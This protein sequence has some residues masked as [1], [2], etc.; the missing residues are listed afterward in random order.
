MPQLEDVVRKH[1]LKNAYDFG[2]ADPKKILGK[3]IAESPQAKGDIPGTLKLAAK[4][5]GE[6]NSMRKEK[7]EEQLAAYRFE[8]K[9]EKA[10]RIEL[11]NAKEGEVVT[12]FPPEPSGY[13]HIGH[14]KAAF[15][16]Y[17]AAKEY[18]GK[19]ILRFDDTNPE[20]ESQEYVDAIRSGLKWLGI[21]W[22]GESYTSDNIPALYSYCDR[23]IK[24]KKAYVCKCAK[25]DISKC[26]ETGKE[27]KCRKIPPEKQ[28]EEWERMRLGEYGE[29]EAL[30]RYRGD[31][32]SDNTVMR[33]PALFRIITRRHYRQGEKYSVWP[34]YDFAV[35]VLDSLE[36]VTH[37][38]RSK[39]YELRRELY[40]SILKNLEMREPELIE[41][42][43]LS[44]KNAPISK[45]LITPLVKEGKV[46]GW[47]DPRLP[48]LS[49]L[50]RRGIAPEAI[51]EFVLG[52]GL[53]KIESEPGWE[54]LLAENRKVLDPVANHYFFVPDPVKIHVENVPGRK[55]ELKMHPK[56]EAVR[57]VEVGNTF[58]IAGADAEGL[59]EDDA[60]RLKD[61]YNVEVI[62]KGDS[63]RCLYKGEEVQ[64]GT[65]KVQWVS[66]PHECEVW[67]VGDLLKNGHYNEESL[68]VEKG[69]C[70]RACLALE[71]GEIIQFERYGFC[72]LDSHS[73]LRFVYSC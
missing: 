16:N 62:T 29:G 5:C 46:K 61:L 53:G 39:E 65:P 36:G 59:K 9:G 67:K 27:C 33:D 47:D 42:A 60:F 19:M 68:R 21:T 2:K 30:V 31:L 41:F 25:E 66:E 26:R 34:S 20:K 10:R 52:F 56:K 70:E 72:R 71:V 54:K 49:G 22:M 57:E 7:V 24:M 8:K 43:R 40:Y 51:R 1:A 3:V 58:Y 23:L 64:K 73:P 32:K 14:A 11:E 15:L 63:I 28:M 45:R 13:P 18:G 35:A 55:V 12:R 44:I 69:Y 38:M 48:T 4:I 37:A 6:V 50:R 17:E